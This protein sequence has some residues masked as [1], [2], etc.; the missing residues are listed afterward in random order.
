MKRL[1][2]LILLFSLNSYSQKSQFE[3]KY[4][5]IFRGTF[6]PNNKY[7]DSFVTLKGEIKI[8]SNEKFILMVIESS[9]IE[10]SVFSGDA[11]KDTLLF[12]LKNKRVYGF[13]N[14]EQ[15]YFI[16]RDIMMKNG[17]SNS[18][19]VRS[20]TIITIDKKINKLIK[21][22]PTLPYFTSGVKSYKTKSFTFNLKN[23]KKSVE[24]LDK[25]YNRVSSFK[26]NGKQTEFR[27]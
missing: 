7:I 25:I 10:N 23:Y 6:N 24:N 21:P 19:I 12:D 3:S 16:P 2:Y 11:D 4:D 14:Q 18:T 17:F 5:L 15:Y 22:S 26:Y 8:I 9:T 13:I 20:D 1:L 27:Y